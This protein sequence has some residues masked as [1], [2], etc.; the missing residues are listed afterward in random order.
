MKI[1]LF[2]LIKSQHEFVAFR[3]QQHYSDITQNVALMPITYFRNLNL[4][5]LEKCP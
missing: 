1:E 5:A 2:H 4:N 3:D